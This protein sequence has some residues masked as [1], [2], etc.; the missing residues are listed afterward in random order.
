LELDLEPRPFEAD[1]LEDFEPPDFAVVELPPF[2]A[3]DPLLD[4]EADE[5]DELLVLPVDD[6]DE[7]VLADVF[8]ELDLAPPLFVTPVV[9]PELRLRVELLP[10]RDRLRFGS[11]PP[12]G[13]LSPTALVASLA[14]SATFPATLPTVF[15]TFLI[16][17]PGSG[18][19]VLLL[20]IRPLAWR[21]T[22]SRSTQ[23]AGSG[24]VDLRLNL[25][26]RQLERHAAVVGA[27]DVLEANLQHRAADHAAHGE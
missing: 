21:S 26:A 4:F 8:D 12:I 13:S 27:L 14:T 1:D 6:F 19:G 7:L 2:E 9:L 23:R 5:P 16:S 15:P 22:A 11:S 18:I 20:G 24:G 10:A 3:V 25:V 17:D